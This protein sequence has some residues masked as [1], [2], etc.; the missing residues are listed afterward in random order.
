MSKQLRFGLYLI[1][2]KRK[3]N[4]KKYIN[5]NRL[6]MRSIYSKKGRKIT[7]SED[8]DKKKKTSS[9]LYK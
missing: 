8:K 5:S 1:K 2:V 6:W 4:T 9:I 7:R 3:W